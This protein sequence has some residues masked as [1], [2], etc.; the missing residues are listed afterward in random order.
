MHQVQVRLAQRVTLPIGPDGDAVCLV[1]GRQV[2]GD[3]AG[4]RAGA[5]RR[6]VG[7]RT[8]VREEDQDLEDGD[9]VNLGPIAGEH[10][11]R[12]VTHAESER[13]VAIPGRVAV[14][15]DRRVDG[16][17][18]RRAELEVAREPSRGAVAVAIAVGGEADLVQAAGTDATVGVE[19]IDEGVGRVLG[20]AQAR[21]RRRSRVHAAGAIDDEHDVER[22]LTCRRLR[23]DRLGR[24][25]AGAEDQCGEEDSNGN[26]REE[27]CSAP[28]A[29]GC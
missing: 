25:Y 29:S 18:I 12:A 2:R 24:R 6:G 3:V 20:P 10:V 17:R 28:L 13:R 11:A 5:R 4:R 8:P 23:V 14:G 16:G 9:A 22:S 19:C 1:R 7:V 26:E 27:P 21:L 15:V